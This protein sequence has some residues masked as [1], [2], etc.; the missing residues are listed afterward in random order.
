MS[1]VTAHGLS[2]IDIGDETLDFL[3]SRNGADIWAQWIA[4]VGVL[5]R[6]LTVEH[7]LRRNADVMTEDWYAVSVRGVQL[8]VIVHCRWGQ[9]R[10]YE[11]EG[12]VDGNPRELIRLEDCGQFADGLRLLLERDGS[13][14]SMDCFVGLARIGFWRLVPPCLFAGEWPSSV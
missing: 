12:C 14:E 3:R 10:V 5:R 13:P 2:R 9:E 6:T 8:G 4:G 11:V 1:D 7:V